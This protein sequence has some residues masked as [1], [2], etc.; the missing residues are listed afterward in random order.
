MRYC[1]SLSSVRYLSRHFTAKSRTIGSGKLQSSSSMACSGLM[2]CQQEKPELTCAIS[3]L[4]FHFTARRILGRISGMLTQSC[5]KWK[6]FS[7]SVISD[8]GSLLHTWR[9]CSLSV[10]VRGL[11][12]ATCDS[13][14]VEQ[15]LHAVGDRPQVERHLP[16]YQCVGVVKQVDVAPGERTSRWRGRAGQRRGCLES[17][18]ALGVDVVTQLLSTVVA[19]SILILSVPLMVHR[20][21][22]VAVD[23]RLAYDGMVKLSMGSWEYKLSFA[24]SIRLG[25]RP[26]MMQLRTYCQGH[27]E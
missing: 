3:S 1:E 4:E 20:D 19:H 15:V 16:C 17:G 21:L 27:T 18:N 2:V 14:G 7:C 13:D 11:S 25:I 22:G 6:S 12:R 5:L 9:S 10:S 24:I 23:I 8:S 26:S